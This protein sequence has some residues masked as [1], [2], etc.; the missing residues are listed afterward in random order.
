MLCCSNDGTESRAPKTL[1]KYAICLPEENSGE[2]ESGL[3]LFLGSDEV[4]GVLVNGRGQLLQEFILGQAQD[5]GDSGGS[6]QVARQLPNRPVRVK[7][8]PGTEENHIS[9]SCRGI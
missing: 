5:G 1:L 9:E 4:D 2:G 8:H 7:L 6:R 3:E